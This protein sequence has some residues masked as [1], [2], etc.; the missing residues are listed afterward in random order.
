MLEAIVRILTQRRKILEALYELGHKDSY[1]VEPRY[2]DGFAV[3]SGVKRSIGSPSDP[4]VIKTADHREIAR[5][6][7]ETDGDCCHLRVTGAAELLEMM[8]ALAFKDEAVN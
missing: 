6:Y 4:F 8:E 3:G 2:I 1:E 7:I 5:Y